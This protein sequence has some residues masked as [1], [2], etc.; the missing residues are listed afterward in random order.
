VEEI[1]W[2]QM[3]NGRSSKRDEFPCL[4]PVSIRHNDLECWRD[5]EI[6]DKL[7]DFQA[8]E[9]LQVSFTERNCQMFSYRI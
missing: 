9:P 7:R 6:A 1:A 5:S 4:G 8:N 3:A 2:I